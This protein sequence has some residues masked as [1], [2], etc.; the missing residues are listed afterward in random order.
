[1]SALRFT[2]SAVACLVVLAIA[3]CRSKHQASETSAGGLVVRRGESSA[4]PVPGAN[5][6]HGS[7]GAVARMPGP[8]CVVG[9][10]N[11]KLMDSMHSAMHRMESMD[12]AQIAALLP[13]HRQMVGAMLSEMG[14]DTGQMSATAAAA[15]TATADSVRRDLAG[16]PQMAS[17]ELK[18][19]IPAHE[20][21]V[22]RLM[23]MH[24]QCQSPPLRPS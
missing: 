20:A 3:A 21:R 17:S 10:T 12:S 18:R 22:M 15:W 1:M 23:K 11:G 4:V 6:G 14:A 13:M 2:G 5:A 8:S 19:T 9:T 16:L 7:T 24:H